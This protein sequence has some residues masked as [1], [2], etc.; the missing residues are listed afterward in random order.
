[1]TIESLELIEGGISSDSRGSVRYC[2]KMPLNE[3]VRFYSIENLAEG[4]VRGWHGHKVEAKAII[5]L[6]G[7]L[8]IGAVEVLDWQSPS[9]SARVNSF[10]LD[11]DSPKT[12]LIPGGYANAIMA[13]SPGAVAGVFSSSSLEMSLEDDYRFPND[14]W[15]L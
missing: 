4:Y 8:R 3:F 5:P 14:F 13:M 15:H 11:A 1:M 10:D 12:L 9:K 6:V 2:N 7:R